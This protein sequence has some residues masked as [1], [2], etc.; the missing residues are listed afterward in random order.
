[1]Q[2]NNEV[3]ALD[4]GTRTIVG[5]VVKK[6][7]DSFRILAQEVMEHDSRVMYDGQIHDIEMVAKS[8]IKLKKSLEK[9]LGYKL[10]KAAVA[11]A[12]RA[13]YTVQAT[14]EKETSPYLEITWEDIKALKADALSNAVKCLS[15]KKKNANFEDYHCVGYSIVNWFLENDPIDNL[16]GQKGKS[17]SVKIV[18]IFLPRVVVESL[19]TVLKRCNMELYSITLEP[20]AASDVVVLPSMR[21]LNIALVDIGAGTSDIAI[22]K[23]GSIVAYGMVPFAGD[24]LTDKICEIFLL[25][26]DEGEKVKRQL[27]Q[28]NLITV[29]DIL[30]QTMKLSATEIVDAIK[31]TIQKLAA[32]IARKILELNG[33]PPAAVICIGGGSLMPK[34]TE[35]IAYNLELPKQRVGIKGRESIAFIKGNDNLSGPFYITPIGIAVNALSGTYLSFIQV[36]VNNKPVHIL[37]QNHSTILDALLY[38]GYSSSQIFGKPG[39][40]K[41]FTLNGKI[42]IIRG[43]MAKPGK[44]FID[45]KKADFDT[46]IWDKAIIDFTPAEDGKPGRARVKD[47]ITKEYMTN[48]TVNGRDLSI[49]PIVEV[50]GKKVDLNYEIPDDAK[51]VVSKRNMIFSDIFNIIS[52]DIKDVKGNLTMEVNGKKVG[53]ASKIEDGDDIKIHW[54][55]SCLP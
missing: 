27:S 15:T 23:D 20:I 5:M 12:G 47:F 2:D 43:T 48:I 26:F 16:L 46:K 53:F 52:F 8:V 13:I 10:K 14:A 18:A 7:G 41:T 1:M 55:N 35:Y 40:A 28:S 32:K 51:V 25:D 39:M 11:A 22:S 19:M 21:K 54:Q 9:Q 36:Y 34:V 4:I 50:N 42:K 44:V 17:I 37:G 29:Q 45:G 33:K 38:T 3:F 6:E 24:E 49:E 30:G 31:S